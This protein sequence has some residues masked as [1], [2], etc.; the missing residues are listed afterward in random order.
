MQHARRRGSRRVNAHRQVHRLVWRGRGWMVRRR[1]GSTPCCIFVDNVREMTLH[2]ADLP[3]GA[4]SP[5]EEVTVGVHSDTVGLSAS[6]VLD[7]AVFERHHSHRTTAP[8]KI[9]PSPATSF[10]R[11]ADLITLDHWRHGWSTHAELSK[12]VGPKRE[13]RTPA[14][15]LEIAGYTPVRRRSWWRTFRTRRANSRKVSLTVRCKV[16]WIVSPPPGQQ[17]P[18]GPK[19][20]L[21]GP[22]KLANLVVIQRHVSV[23]LVRCRV[24]TRWPP[25]E[26][27]V[28]SVVQHER[29]EV[30]GKLVDGLDIA[31]AVGDQP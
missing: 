26:G 16:Q 6:N 7:T 23:C 9:P 14:D 5:C 28:R 19:S 18:T 3:T 25:R 22:Q 29:T 31:A 11:S 15:L 1:R 8:P 21:T 12:L 24:E 30:V 17:H 10:S 20:S 2:R 13:E 4:T 27:T